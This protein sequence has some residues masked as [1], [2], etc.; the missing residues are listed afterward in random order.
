M[1]CAADHLGKRQCRGLHSRQIVPLPTY[2]SGVV[3]SR[4]PA[5]EAEDCAPPPLDPCA[6]AD[7]IEVLGPQLGW[8]VA[9]LGRG[10]LFASEDAARDVP[11]RLRGYQV[12]SLA[13]RAVPRNQVAL[14]QQVGIDRTVMTYLLDDLQAA[15]LIERRPD[16]ADRRARQIVA[17]AAGVAL[18][19]Q[20][21]AR[22][23]AAEARVLST[24]S[25]KEQDQL[26][27]MMRRVATVVQAT[28]PSDL[29]PEH[30]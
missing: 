18:I 14:A 10:L 23:S 13:A 6:K 22:I 1:I 25:A 2:A 8:S 16:P 3:T 9:T 5:L 12:L 19:E 15:G 11:G 21:A 17:T 20:V 29:C 4:V 24:L 26:R 30:G 28:E 27:A 7:A